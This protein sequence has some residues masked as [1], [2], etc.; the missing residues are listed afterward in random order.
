MSNILS[1]KI[2]KKTLIA[3][4]LLLSHSSWGQNKNEQV[5]P[6]ALSS[7]STEMKTSDKHPLEMMKGKIEDISKRT[8]DAKHFKNKDGSYTALIGAGAMHYQKN[9]KWE[10]IDTKIK[11][12]NS[13]DFPYANTSNLMESHF[14]ASSNKGIISKTKEGEVKEFLNGKMYWEANG[15]AVNTQEA[16][17]VKATIDGDKI[18]YHNLFGKISAEYIVNVGQRKL[19]YIIPNKESLGNIPLN[20]E[21][22][23]FSEEIVL[24][25]SWS[26]KFTENGIV[27]KE[28]NGKEIYLYE[29]PYSTDAENKLTRD[30]NT[31]F[32][33]SSSDNI[34]TIKTKV[35]TSWLL[36]NERIFPVKVD[37]TVTVYPN[38]ANLWTGSAYSDGVKSSLGVIRF[39]R[40]TTGANV[41]GWAKFNISSM[42]NN[43][44]VNN[45]NVN[46]Y[47]SGVSANYS[48]SNGHQLSFSQLLIDPVTASGANIYNTIAVASYQPFQTNAINAIGYKNHTLTSTNALTNDFNNQKPLGW[49]ALGFMPNGNFS[50]GVYLEATG[51]L[52]TNQRPYLIVD[53]SY[54]LTVS[55]AYAGASYA[56]GVHTPP[57]NGPI[58]ITAGTRNGYVC[59]GWNG[60]TGDIPATGTAAAF[61]MT[62][63]LTQS[64]S[65]SWLWQQQPGLPNNISFHNYGGTE[66]LAFNN[67]RS[68]STSPVFRLSHQTD[69]ASDYEIEINTNPIFSGGTSWTQSF[70]G[71]YPL[72]TQTNFTFTN[73]FTPT[74]NTTYYVRARVKG[75]ANVWSA[76][77]T[78][79]Y[80]FTHE[81]ATSTPNWFQTTQANS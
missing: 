66:Q 41:R 3:F 21:Y 17:D 40:W 59:I 48:P 49:F 28:S 69:P 43:I 76:W 12:N 8:A 60:G 35:K 54:R 33:I 4:V 25:K 1:S 78:E 65:I 7:S 20:A 24:P 29:K 38:N 45:V 42:P 79:T 16:A 23:V 51:H 81:A 50:S 37:P 11:R 73:G 13:Q 80:S 14:G 34:L 5:L 58:N 19:N 68:N 75:E 27:I 31:L 46:Y 15:N 2:L 53:Y 74:N 26:H 57:T 64:S 71:T 61:N 52:V 44:Q 10:D 47:I 70:T 9:G 77:T 39:G 63:G 67:S 22:L 30:K 56:N 32:E 62:G 55:N 36:S 6:Q 72:N 18:Y